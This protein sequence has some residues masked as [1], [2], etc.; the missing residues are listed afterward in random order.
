MVPSFIE[1]CTAMSTG[2]PML[3]RRQ[4]RLAAVASLRNAGLS[5]NGVEV[6]IESPGDWS[7]P[8]ENLPA[9]YIQTSTETKN[10]LMAG[11]P[12]FNTTI[13]LL[14]KATVQN[15]SAEAAQDDVEELWYAIEN[16]LLTDRAVVAMTQKISSVTTSLEVK[17][18]GSEHLAGIAGAFDVQVIEVYDPTNN[19]KTNQVALNQVALNQVCIDIDLKNVY[20]KTGTY[21]N[22]DFQ[23]SVTTAPR[24]SGPDGRKEG[25]LNIHLEGN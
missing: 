3:A 13:T 21:P 1:Y 9:I 8:A 16:A 7:N 22:A 14:I 2:I 11:L 25:S 4:L 19:V 18:T 15:T 12:E 5:V 6:D 17:A 10:A 23:N 20:D 24:N